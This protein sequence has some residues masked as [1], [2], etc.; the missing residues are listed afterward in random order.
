MANLLNKQSFD[1]K[2]TDSSSR[3][4][5]FVVA[6]LIVTVATFVVAGSQTV[7]NALADTGV[8]D[9]ENALA[10]YYTT[11]QYNNNAE[12]TYVTNNPDEAFSGNRSLRIISNDSV[13][14][15]NKTEELTRWL[16][17]IDTLPA[18]PGDE[19][20][21]EAM[22]RTRDVVDS[23]TISVTFFDSSDWRSWSQTVSSPTSVYKQ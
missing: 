6:A 5:L 9:F 8:D 10:H 15:K 21:V 22:M 7:F 16:T 3:S 2:A 12:F 20:R 13:P 1:I 23:A 19:Y 4:R 11:H 17:R 18:T 14:E